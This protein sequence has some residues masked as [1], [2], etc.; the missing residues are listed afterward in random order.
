M[1]IPVKKTFRLGSTENGATDSLYLTSW[2]PSVREMNGPKDAYAE[3]EGVY[4]IERFNKTG[5]RKFD[6]LETG[7]VAA[8]YWSRTA[9]YSNPANIVDMSAYGTSGRY[10]PSSESLLVFGF[11][12]GIETIPVNPE[13]HEILETWEQIN[14]RMGDG[15]YKTAYSIGDWKY[16]NFGETYGTQVPVEIVA[17]DTDEYEDP[18]AQIAPEGQYR[19]RFFIPTNSG[20]WEL[21]ETQYIDIRANEFTSYNNTGRKDWYTDKY[22]FSMD[23]KSTEFNKGKDVFWDDMFEVHNHVDLYGYSCLGTFTYSSS[24][25]MP[26]EGIPSNVPTTKT[27]PIT[28][29][30]RDTLK[31]EYAWNYSVSNVGGYPQSNLKTVIDDAGI[32]ITGD[33]NPKPYVIAVNKTYRMGKD[34]S[35]VTNSNSFTYWAPSIYE[36]GTGNSNYDSLK[37]SSGV[38]Y[39]KFSDNVSRIKVETE[40]SSKM[41]W[42][43]RSAHYN[44]NGNAMYVWGL[45][46]SCG[47]YITTNACRVVLGFC[48]AYNPSGGAN[49]Q[50]VNPETHEINL[51]WD[52]IAT[53][54]DN[55]T[56]TNVLSVGD[57]K[58]LETT[59]GT[60]NMQIVGFDKDKV[61]DPNKGKVEYPS[62]IK[63]LERGAG[64]EGLVD[65]TWEDPDDECWEGTLI[66]V[67][68]NTQGYKISDLSQGRV[69]ANITERNKYKYTEYVSWTLGNKNYTYNFVPYSKYG[70]NPDSITIFSISNGMFPDDGET[71]AIPDIPTFESPKA[72]I[73]WVM[74]EAHIVDDSELDD[75]GEVEVANPSVI[76]TDE[77]NPY[78]LEVNKSTYYM[79]GLTFRAEE[80]NEKLKAYELSLQEIG[81]D[82]YGS[83]E[84]NG[85]SYSDF[86]T[87]NNS[88]K[89][90]SMETNEPCAYGLRSIT[91]YPR[92]DNTCWICGIGIDG[93]HQSYNPYNLNGRVYGFCTGGTPK[94]E[95]P[96]PVTDYN[97]TGFFAGW[98]L[99][100]R[101]TD[102]LDDY[103]TSTKVFAMYGA[104]L[105][106]ET[107]INEGTL[108]LT[109]TTK[110][111]YTTVKGLDDLPDF[112]F[113]QG[114]TG[115]FT[116]AI[117]TYNGDAYDL[118]S[119]VTISAYR[120]AWDLTIQ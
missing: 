13:T 19:V 4:Y 23:D 108:C 86:F 78:V 100:V 63:N 72:P 119:V 54:V 1:L 114:Q 44:G 109:E 94:V 101:F 50:P 6:N 98:Q 58:P 64:V 97:E 84:K 28:W 22:Y 41:D 27:A 99:Y 85:V 74:K 71:R 36:I 120:S 20:S 17:F 30:C 33:D 105:S 113:G 18:N 76:L 34:K 2:I 73:T 12:T 67:V 59:V 7:K 75:L 92:G 57:Y 104:N 32:S 16:V 95:L 3:A 110:N 117:V 25:I 29:I 77:V 66:V 8:T 15:T 42:W 21:A 115:Y 91:D 80:Q 81:V 87:D 82:N 90:N 53:L 118:N 38:V 46:G 49:K 14:E 88:R 107:V 112:K 26:P 96:G 79:N 45:I 83:Q 48:T 60:V 52:E 116:I 24:Y 11:C 55:D 103:W 31:G 65:F 61:T 69:I 89:K 51:S 5:G 70:F 9:D 39:T 68:D 93:A 47:N 111:Q 106:A 10:S 62:S 40:S 102:P 35:G 56:Y 37:E 43:L